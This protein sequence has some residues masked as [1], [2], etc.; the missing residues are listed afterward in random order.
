MMKQ[1]QQSRKKKKK[2]EVND[3]INHLLID[4]SC[5]ITVAI[6][7]LNA[8]FKDIN[9]N[10][11]IL[12]YNINKDN[13]YIV[14]EFNNISND[15]GLFLNSF[16][17]NLLKNKNYKIKKIYLIIKHSVDSKFVSVEVSDIITYMENNITIEQFFSKIRWM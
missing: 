14:S 5:G 13:L 1:L 15:F 7:C 6:S 2:L 17:H 11:S 3:I 16:Y 10:S 8:H 9:S 12:E 4:D